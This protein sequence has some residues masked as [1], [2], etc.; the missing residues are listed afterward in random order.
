MTIP[1]TSDLCDACE[2]AAA[3][4]LSFMSIGR[5]TAF[6]GSI[7]TVSCTS[8]IAPLREIVHQP[9]QGQVLVIDAAPIGFRA[10]F[11]DVM[12]ALAV[13]NGWAGVV[14]HGWV[15]DRREIDEM[16]IGVKALGT[17]PRRASVAGGGEVDGTLRFGNIAFAPGSRLV[18]DEDGVIVLP[19]GLNESDI[20]IADTVAATAA[21]VAA[22]RG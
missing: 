4:E 20:A 13:R 9:G 2:A 6:A 22:P 19:P 21:Y 11:G 7:R 16:A 17:S 1:K 5:R 14:V 18:A 8:G 15:R 3:C 12:A 10:V